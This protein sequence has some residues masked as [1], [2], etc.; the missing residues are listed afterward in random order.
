MLVPQTVVIDAV[1]VVVLGVTT[2][3]TLRRRT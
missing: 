2:L 3:L 1:A